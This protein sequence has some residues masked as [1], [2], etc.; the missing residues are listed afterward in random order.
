[1]T[2]VVI[3]T[4]VLAVA[5]NLHGEVSPSCVAACAR[6]LENVS[7]M[8]RVVIDND[9]RILREY[10]NVTKTGQKTPGTAF[11]KWLH[12]NMWTPDRCD[13]IVQPH[14]PQRPP[15]ALDLAQH[16]GTGP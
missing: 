11:L 15:S 16:R 5:D 6:A 10:K 1:M 13:Q 4:N 14:E 12:Q 7:K 8:H 3:D 9:Q 2:P